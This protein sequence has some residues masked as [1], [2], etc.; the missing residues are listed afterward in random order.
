MTG[1]AILLYNRCVPLPRVWLDVIHSGIGLHTQGLEE[2]EEGDNHLCSEL[3]SAHWRLLTLI[4]GLSWNRYDFKPFTLERRKP[5]HLI[6]QMTESGWDLKCH[7]SS[8]S[9]WAVTSDGHLCSHMFF[10]LIL[11]SH[12]NEMWDLFSSTLR[13]STEELTKTIQ[14][15]FSYIMFPGNWFSDEKQTMTITHWPFPVSQ[16]RRWKTARLVG[17]S[18]HFHPLL[19]KLDKTRPCQCR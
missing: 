1:G 4:L 3:R 16:H 17:N 12:K 7:H 6:I 11:N 15:Y 8:E 10:V 13:N 14:T 9:C 5:V 19:R 2:G 18:S